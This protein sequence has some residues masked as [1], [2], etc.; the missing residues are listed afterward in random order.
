M[1][2]C[3]HV[4]AAEL[5][6]VLRSLHKQQPR[7]HFEKETFN[8]RRHDVR[9][10]ITQ[11][12]IK[13]HDGHNDGTGDENHGEEQVFADERRRQRRGRVDLGDQQQKDNERR[14]DGHT[15]RDLLARVGRHVEQQHGHRTDDDTRQNEVDRVE[16]SLSS[17][18]DVE[19]DV[20]VRFRTAR[21]E[22]LVLLR[23]DRQ[24]VPFGA[25]VVVV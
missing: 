19:L 12:Y 7:K 13:H 14:E 25:L 15:H 3:L 20:R 24:Q 17:D 5:N 11:V 21:I 23:L 10:G 18:R 4:S 16:Q 2:A 6:V 22:L 9:S 8:P 1:I